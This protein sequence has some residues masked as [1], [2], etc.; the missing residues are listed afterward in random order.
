M[1]IPRRQRNR[2][3][4]SLLFFFFL[5]PFLT[6]GQRA[7]VDGLVGLLHD[8]LLVDAVQGGTGQGHEAG[9]RRL[10]DTE[11]ANELEEGVDPGLLRGAFEQVSIGRMGKSSE[12][13]R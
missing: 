11:G 3:A 10:E 2:E 13:E 7:D 6:R 5:P 12:K 9:T 1:N 8:G 4:I